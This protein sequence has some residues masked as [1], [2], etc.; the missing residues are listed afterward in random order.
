[1]ETNRKVKKESYCNVGFFY[2][3]ENN[4]YCVCRSVIF[5]IT[6]TIITPSLVSRETTYFF[7]EQ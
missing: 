1:M 6:Y 2:L 4:P 5:C 7:G 3:K